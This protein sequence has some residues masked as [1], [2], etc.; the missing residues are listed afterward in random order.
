M[1]TYTCK[2]C[3]PIDAS[4]IDAYVALIG[5]TENANNS[6]ANAE[7]AT[8]AANNAASSAN[9]AAT[10]ATNAANSATAAAAAAN[11]AGITQA[12]ASVD[13]NTGTPSVDVSLVNKKLSL[14]FHNI[15]GE[16]GDKGD[17]GDG[18]VPVINDLVTGG[19]NAAL[20]AEMG[21]TL[22][23]TKQATLVSGTNIKT[24]NGESLLGEGNIIAGDPN[25][26][27]YVEQTL[28]DA[29]KAQARTNIDSYQKPSTGIPATDLASAAQTSL[30]KA[31][32]AY[33]KPSAGIPKLDLE[34]GVQA[35]LDLAD[36]AIQAR[37]M[38][39]VDPTITPADYATKEELDE[40][41]AK[42]IKLVGWDTSNTRSNVQAV[43]DCW[44]LSNAKKIYRCTVWN[45]TPQ[46]SSYV[47][48]PFYN[49]AIYQ[50]QGKLYVWNGSDLVPDTA[51]IYL[52]MGFVTS[53]GSMNVGDIY[54][55]TNVKQL[56][57]KTDAYDYIVV[58]FYDDALYIYNHDVYVWNG[59]DLVKKSC[60]VED[61]LASS[62][63]ENALSA[64]K[65]KYLDENKANLAD[66][67]LFNKDATQVSGKYV[68]SDGT[69]SS[70]ANSTASYLIP[71][72]PNTLYSWKATQ[73]NNNY[74]ARFVQSNGTTGL[75]LLDADGNT[76]P[77]SNGLNCGIIKSPSNAAYFQFTTIFAGGNDIS[78][79]ACLIE[80]PVEIDVY[81]P[82]GKAVPFEEMPPRVKEL[83]ENFNKD[84]SPLNGKKLY[85]LG[86][87][88]MNGI[89]VPS[90]KRLYNQ[91]ASLTGA[92]SF[93]LS[94]DGSVFMYP[95]LADVES[96]YWQLTQVPLDADYIIIQGGV[97]GVNMTNP[98]AS[99][100][101]PMGAITDSYGSTFDKATQ[102][103]CL[104]AI[105][106][107]LYDNFPG[108]KVGFIVTYQIGGGYSG[109]LSYWKAKL[110][111]FIPV[112]EKWGVPCL[113]WR[114]SGVNLAANSEHYG[115]DGW[116]TYSQFDPAASYDTD[117]KVIHDSKLYKANEPI[118]PGAWDSSQWTLISSTRYDN[119]HC[120]E[121]AYTLLASFTR[122]WMESL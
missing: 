60:I 16:K 103:G 4:I 86:D 59:S 70:N 93:N 64:S 45:G 90:N 20:S 100:Y 76:L 19:T 11:A 104:E 113:D 25:A 107:Y 40:L 119:W 89:L 14:S 92:T 55:N 122:K 71:I 74:I 117:D 95:W 26:V 101:A 6:A 8:T 114:M 24:V 44:Y 49:G 35:S 87:S 72:K 120:N 99:N 56:R 66:T 13:S 23:N 112:L 68:G 3:K 57:R 39:E 81:S 9:N 18:A 28:T 91:I 97:N 1:A 36:S 53:Q 41:E 77:Y 30:G 106:K 102:V 38:G 62:S 10:Q 48:V 32:T 50:F 52:V 43:G 105:C 80:S 65:G 46:S 2:G 121:T 116:A 22:N 109:Y 78:A 58:P 118:S 84:I 47:E 108:K 54:Y 31:D 82:Y 96:I 98:D 67:N 12:D 27:K 83:V 5:A 33:Q 85:F 63:T 110:D 29:Q 34:S 7:V 75:N 88:I 15:K 94:K 17:R 69:L 21:K 42:L 79:S 115:I 37:P 73:P 61:S 111:Q 51:R